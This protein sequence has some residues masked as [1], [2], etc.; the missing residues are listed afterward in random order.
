MQSRFVLSKNK[1]KFMQTR[2]SET[3]MIPHA[4]LIDNI[5]KKAVN[6][7][8]AYAIKH[9]LILDERTERLYYE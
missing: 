8:N 6:R 2:M 7:Y 1:G 3:D 4:D 5:E 9:E